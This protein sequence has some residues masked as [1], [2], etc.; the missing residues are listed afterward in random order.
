MTRLR[1]NALRGVISDDPL[2]SGATTVNSTDF[3]DLPTVAGT[4]DLLIT[5]DPAALY[6]DP[7]IVRVT[8]HTA[9]AT[10]VTVV[11]GQLGTSARA[12]TANVQWVHAPATVDVIMQCTSTTR[13]SVGLYA[14]L[15]IFE[16]D[17][18]SLFRYD[19]AAWVLM[20]APQV[21]DAA[22][23]FNS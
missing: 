5:L 6:G 22:W 23:F 12:H 17:T 2:T 1:T 8:A 11:R 9:A 3:A 10:S 4:D 7:E 21:T 14:G 20:V 16:T 13:P 15:H 18:L 19:G